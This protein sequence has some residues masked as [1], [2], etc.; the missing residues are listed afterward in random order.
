MGGV[1]CE[2]GDGWFQATMHPCCHHLGCVLLWG[3]NCWSVQ[4]PALSHLN[5]K[6]LSVILVEPRLCPRTES[7]LPHMPGSPLQ[8]GTK[9]RHRKHKSC[10]WVTGSGGLRG[11]TLF[12]PR[13]SRPIYFSCLR[14]RHCCQPLICSCL[15]PGGQ[16]PDLQVV[17]PSWPLSL[18]FK[19]PLVPG[20]LFLG[21]DYGRTQGPY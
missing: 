18:A 7:L 2:A 14:T 1:C 3:L 20:Q 5:L 6:L 12:L 9:C 4:V 19:K 17:F 21:N 13:G 10:G 15:R 16:G 11:A 8:Q